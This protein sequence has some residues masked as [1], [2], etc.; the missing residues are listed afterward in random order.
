MSSCPYRDLY[1][2]QTA[3]QV[4]FSKVFEAVRVS[5]GDC[6]MG[7]D[8]E[9]RLQELLSL[10]MQR[11]RGDVSGSS[12]SEAVFRAPA[13]VS[14]PTPRDIFCEVARDARTRTRTRLQEIYLTQ[15][16]QSQQK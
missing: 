7:R 2:S 4:G 8:L 9:K 5:A 12:G 15:Q 11:E 16:Q 14:C 13:G 10:E 3:F 6:A 1:A